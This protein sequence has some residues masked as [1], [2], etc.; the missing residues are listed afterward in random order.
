[1][2]A[3]RVLVAPDKF[4]GSL[5]A[6][7]AAR[8]IARGIGTVDNN[9]ATTTACPVADGGEG[10][11]DAVLNAGFRHV[12]VRA[13]GPL[14]NPVDTGF[15]VRDSHAV[16]ELADICGW[17]RL[18]VT[19]PAP[20]LASSYGVGEVMSA[21]FDHGC[22]RITLAVGGSASTDGGAG[23]LQALGARLL[24]ST[25]RELSAGGGALTQLDDVD[26]GGLD[27]RISHVELAL[28]T[29]VTNP[30][31]GPSGAASV[32]GPQKGAGACE[33][34]TLE[35]GLARLAVLLGHESSAQQAGAGAAGGTGF[36]VLTALGAT[37]ISGAA[38]VLD[39]VAL[40]DRLA[41]CDVVI[42]GEGSLD[43]QSKHGKA[44]AAVAALGRERGIP[45]LALAGRCSLDRDELAA[46]GVTRSWSLTSLEPDVE[47][48]VNDVEQL[49]PDLAANAYTHWQGRT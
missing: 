4:K 22:D 11:L 23:M 27:P 37:R 44:P 9:R 16:V 42:I 24:D 45:V 28:A 33:V 5:T 1:M 49:L 31:L 26:T 15:A 47:R 19:G 21:A 7:A 14:G 48:C 8:L 2:G 10:T 41:E 39:T 20:L 35:S 40:A 43:E 3:P 34:A 36:G 17:Q 29:D 18:P 38:F 32:F 13:S 30:L 6:R 12:P 46:M 25:G